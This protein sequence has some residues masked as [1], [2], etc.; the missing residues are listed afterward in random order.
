AWSIDF[1]KGGIPPTIT[2]YITGWDS[3]GVDTSVLAFTF[4]LATVTAVVFGLVPAL[5]ASRAGLGEGLKEGGRALAGGT[6][7]HRLRSALV[8]LQVSLALV[9]LSSAGALVKGFLRASN[10][11]RGLE[12]RGVLS[13]YVALPDTR[14]KDPAAVLALQR[15][16]LDELRVLPG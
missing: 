4:A 6:G 15:R 10:P 16:V 11:H 14:Y 7:M 8:V 1:I 13:F 5:S 12:P 2:R 3:M 9:L